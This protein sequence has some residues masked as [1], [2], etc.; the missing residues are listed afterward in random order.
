MRFMKPPAFFCTE[1]AHIDWARRLI[2][3]HHQ[4]HPRDMGAEAVEA[5]LS[6]LAV[7]RQVAAQSQNQ[8]K[9]AILYLYKQGLGMELPW[10]HELSQGRRLR[11][12]R[13]VPTPSQVR[14][15]IAR[16]LCGKGICWMDVGLMAQKPRNPCPLLPPVI[17]RAG[18]AV[19]ARAGNME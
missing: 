10:L 5:F 17:E 9:S 16:P 15:L 14:G 8:A 7:D 4:C 19:A 18:K 11:C 1:E 12:L 3:F 6:H 2:L 13:A